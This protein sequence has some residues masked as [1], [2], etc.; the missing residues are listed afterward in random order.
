MVPSG[1]HVRFILCRSS[2]KM[3]WPGA[4]DTDHGDIEVIQLRYRPTYLFRL[5]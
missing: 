2:P 1:R 5:K 4:D 3:R